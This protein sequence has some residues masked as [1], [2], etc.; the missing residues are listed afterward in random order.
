MHCSLQDSLW[1]GR[2]RRGV[3][4][5]DGK[6]VCQEVVKIKSQKG[7]WGL[8]CEDLESQRTS[9]YFISRQWAGTESFEQGSVKQ[10]VGRIGMEMT[11]A[12]GNGGTSQGHWQK[13]EPKGGHR[14]KGRHA[15]RIRVARGESAREGD[16]TPGV[17]GDV[18]NR[19]RWARH[20]FG[21]LRRGRD[22]RRLARRWKC[23]TG[24]WKFRF[25]AQDRGQS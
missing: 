2:T 18:T 4:W 17:G 7:K 22:D 24:P 23:S 20:R 16:D 25:G 15:G 14:L 13:E 5:G 12:R 19:R 10:T 9:V 8:D 3:V 11:E 1:S 6:G 21:G